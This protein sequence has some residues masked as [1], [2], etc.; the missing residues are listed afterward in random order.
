M[1][2]KER[3][4][5][6]FT[7]WLPAISKVETH[8]PS[9]VLEV[10]LTNLFQENFCSEICSRSLGNK[11]STAFQNCDLLLQTSL[12]NRLVPMR[13]NVTAMKLQVDSSVSLYQAAAGCDLE[14]E[15]VAGDSC[16]QLRDMGFCEQMRLRKISNGRNL[17]CS[18]CGS[19][20]AISRHLAEQIQV[21]EVN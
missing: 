7:I 16:K 9:V 10:L 15:S 5:L 21:R 8:Q 14:I 1:A 17:I 13:M 20:L 2:S 11:S 6:K 19:R 12:N 4:F 3:T 18:V